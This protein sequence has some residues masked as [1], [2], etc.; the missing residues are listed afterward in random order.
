MTD[1]DRP[2]DPA[3]LRRVLWEHH[4]HDALYGDDGE[5]QC[6]RYPPADF[7]RDHIDSL[8]VH[9]SWTPLASLRHGGEPACLCGTDEALARGET[10][11]VRLDIVCPK[12]DGETP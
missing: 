8:I 5:M 10:S 2:T 4:G 9:V 12:H 11:W 1:L 3:F 6:N 7:R